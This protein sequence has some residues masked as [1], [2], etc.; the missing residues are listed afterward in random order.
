MNKKILIAI[1]LSLYA[2]SGISVA[3]AQESFWSWLITFHRTKGVAPSSDE[4]YIEECGACHFPYQPGLLPEA[5][6]KKL[7]SAKAL[8]DHFKENAELDEGTRSKLL[9]YAINHSAEKSWYKRSR[10]IMSTLNKDDAPMRITNVP[11]IKAKHHEVNE[12]VIDKS[13]KIKSLSYCDKCHQRAEE[14]V[15]DDDTVLI[16]GHGYW[17]W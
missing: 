2:V 8:E 9:D 17:T 12:E 11:Y 1:L 5:S 10:K 3:Y 15:F 13:G 4:L 7:L 6:W 14:G 16:P